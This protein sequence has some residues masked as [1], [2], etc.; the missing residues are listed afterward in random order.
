MNGTY[1][2]AL[3]NIGKNADFKKDS[4]EGNLRKYAI[5]RRVWSLASNE[6]SWITRYFMRQ[7]TG[8]D[9]QDYMNVDHEW[10]SRLEISGRLYDM[11]FIDTSEG[12]VKDNPRALFLVSV[13]ENSNTGF[14]VALIKKVVGEANSISQYKKL[15]DVQ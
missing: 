15:Y 10:K 9:L 13:R 8:A 1:E 11:E 3:E 5:L 12:W 14:Y 2:E 6:K 7:A 4:K